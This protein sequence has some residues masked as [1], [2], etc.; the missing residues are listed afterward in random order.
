MSTLTQPSSLPGNG[1]SEVNY[2]GFPSSL[3][4]NGGSEVNYPV[5]HH[6]C[7]VMVGQKSIIPF[8]IIIAG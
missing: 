2:P 1:G 7:G 4:G 5:S 6:H 8:P 3:R